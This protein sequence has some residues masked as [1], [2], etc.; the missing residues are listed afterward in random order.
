MCFSYLWTLGYFKKIYRNYQKFNYWLSYKILSHD[1][2]GTSNNGQTTSYR[3]LSWSLLF[4]ESTFHSDVKTTIHL[5][6]WNN[7]HSTSGNNRQPMSIR[8][9]C[10]YLVISFYIF[11]AVY[12]LHVIQINDS[13]CQ[14]PFDCKNLGLAIS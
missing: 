14:R 12:F 2:E 1:G 10:A 4:V 6:S 5:Q 13:Q 7:R 3:R 11:K 8:R 9:R